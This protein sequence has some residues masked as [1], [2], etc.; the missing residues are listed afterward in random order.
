MSLFK[1]LLVS[2]IILFISS[3]G[4]AASIHVDEVSVVDISFTQTSRHIKD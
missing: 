2:A 4:N 3:H 1:L